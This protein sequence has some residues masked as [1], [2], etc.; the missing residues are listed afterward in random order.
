MMSDP[1]DNVIIF[2]TIRQTMAAKGSSLVASSGRRFCNLS[3]SCHHSPT[4]GPGPTLLRVSVP[5]SRQP[6]E[7]TF[8]CW[9]ARKL[10]PSLALFAKGMQDL[11][12]IAATRAGDTATSRSCSSTP[13][14]AVE[15]TP[16]A[17][18]ECLWGRELPADGFAQA[19]PSQHMVSVVG[20]LQVEPSSRG[21]IAAPSFA[22]FTLLAN[23][24][25]CVHVF[26]RG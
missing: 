25:R 13:S 6:L 16:P 7:I 12:V 22:V 26:E 17:N 3:S 20:M 24:A 9:I 21:A 4:V 8:D 18:V 19:M 23:V 1:S 14:I 10:D 15:S 11:L 5:A 2:V